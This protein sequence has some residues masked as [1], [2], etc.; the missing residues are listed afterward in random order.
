MCCLTWAYFFGTL[1]RAEHTI[2]QSRQCFLAMKAVASRGVRQRILLLLY[3][4]LVLSIIEYGFGLMTLTD[5]H[6]KRLDTIHK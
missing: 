5:T 2:I 4:T 6:L 1:S 3:Q